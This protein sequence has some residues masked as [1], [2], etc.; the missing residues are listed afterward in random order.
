MNNNYQLAGTPLFLWQRNYYT[1]L[2]DFQAATGKD[3][4]SIALNPSFISP[5]GGGDCGGVLNGT[6]PSAYKLSSGSPMVGR[7]TNISAFGITPP[8]TGYYGT[9]FQ[10]AAGYNIGIDSGLSSPAGP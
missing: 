9:P 5:G 7:G 6:C 1:S 3:V 10:N 4:N 2:G 8:P